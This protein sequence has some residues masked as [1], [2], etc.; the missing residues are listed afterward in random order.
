MMTRV[1]LELP[2]VLA[3]KARKAGVL[4]RDAIRSL[5]E[6]EILRR[7]AA[8]RLARV[9]ARLQAAWDGPPLNDEQVRAEVNQVIAEV[10]AEGRAK[11]H[12]PPS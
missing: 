8:R 4:K 11:P 10:R 9:S 12:A 7:K 5:V 1:V 6:D 2:D 3:R